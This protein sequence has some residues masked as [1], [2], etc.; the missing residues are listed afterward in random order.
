LKNL[1]AREI[2]GRISEHK[3]MPEMIQKK[4]SRQLSGASWALTA[5]T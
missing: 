2:L 3:R 1:D 5:V 4:K